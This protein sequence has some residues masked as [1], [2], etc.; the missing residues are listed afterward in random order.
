M[1]SERGLFKNAG[2]DVAVTI[3]PPNQMTTGVLGG[4]LD[5]GLANTGAIL[6]A[7]VHAL[8]IY[9][10]APAA[11]YSQRQPI[12]YIVVAAGSSIRTAKDLAGKTIG[13]F[14]IHD[15]ASTALLQWLD[16]N[17]ADSKSVH[18]VEVPPLSA[19]IA[20]TTGRI[21][22]AILNEPHVSDA[23][24]TLRPI[25]LTYSMVAGGKPFQTTGVVV[26]KP[27]ADA[28]LPLVR[29]L[30]G[31][32]RESAQWANRN[33]DQAATLISKLMKIE[34]DVVK[35]IPRVQWGE[36]PSPALVQPVID[37]MAKYAV[38]PQRFPAQEVFVPGV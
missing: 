4:S 24:G 25:G 5:V 2:L 27:W 6:L 19:G 14:A 8:P 13:V 3:V 9:L 20:V 31:V 28:N 7:H 33:P 38:L 21:D 10:V 32:V 16:V 15:M 37:V 18:M 22:A 11:V 36:S 29:R 23:K 17:G 35:A 34:L 12:S 1:A 26:N 30:A